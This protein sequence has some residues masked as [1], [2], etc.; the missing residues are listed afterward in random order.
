MKCYSYVVRRDYGFAPNPFGGY[1]TLA[2]CKPNIRNSAVIGDLVIGT[3][4]A[5]YKAGNKLVYAMH[6][7]EKLHFNEYWSDKRFTYKKPVPNG[8][9]KQMYGDNIYYFDKEQD[10]WNQVNSHHSNPDGTINVYNRDRDLQSEYVLIS[11]EF[12]YFGHNAVIIPDE[13][14]GIRKKGPGH[15]SDFSEE[16]ILKFLTWIKENYELGY[17]GNPNYF[18]NFKRY[19]GK[20]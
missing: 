6:V 12:W 15:R 18:T 4:S 3:G 7:S 20:S 10:R 13:F 11:K 2:T 16:Y 8:S 5:D 9:L 19:D 1:C 17:R 14:L